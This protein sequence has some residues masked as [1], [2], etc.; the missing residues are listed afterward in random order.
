MRKLKIVQLDE[1]VFFDSHLD[2]RD[3]FVWIR[4]ALGSTK[5]EKS[6]TQTSILLVS[7]DICLFLSLFPQMKFLKYVKLKGNER[8]S[9]S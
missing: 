1:E 9:Y 2:R 8:S 6:I 5:R 4:P 3:A 7:D